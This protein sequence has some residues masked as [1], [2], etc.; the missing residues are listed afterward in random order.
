M[1]LLFSEI[2]PQAIYLQHVMAAA[3]KEM[4]PS[5]PFLGFT[6]QIRLRIR[7]QV[8]RK[9]PSER[10]FLFAYATKYQWTKKPFFEQP[11]DIR[12][13]SAVTHATDMLGGHPLLY[14]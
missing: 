1:T 13:S 14:R 9:C 7:R 4:P 8:N 5:P 3:S 11:S 2:S 6:S 10:G 12:F